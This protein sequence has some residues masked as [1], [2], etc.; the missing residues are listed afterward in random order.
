MKTYLP[1]YADVLDEKGRPFNDILHSE[2]LQLSTSAQRTMTGFE[3]EWV[4]TVHREKVI[5]NLTFSLKEI[6]IS[7]ARLPIRP[8]S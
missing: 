2:L 3:G 6:Y 1:F 8:I 4:T 7:A 5:N